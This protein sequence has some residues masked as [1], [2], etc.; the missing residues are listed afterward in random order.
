MNGTVR[1]EAVRRIREESARRL[2]RAGRR[3]VAS[4]CAL[5]AL[6]SLTAFAAL[7]PRRG[8]SPPEVATIAATVQPDP[9]AARAR[10]H[11]E[12]CA[13]LLAGSSAMRQR[14]A[15][16]LAAVHGKKQRARVWAEME[17]LHGPLARA[18][19]TEGCPVM[20]LKLEE[21][22]RWQTPHGCGCTPCGHGF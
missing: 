18:E 2:A 20:P 22:A 16:R 14:L 9:A 17:Q 15:I 8:A 6:L 1:D 7:E 10:V 12:M 5:G 13:K 11:Q 19:A 4:R 21:R 3:A